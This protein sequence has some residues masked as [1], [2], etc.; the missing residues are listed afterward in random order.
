MPNGVSALATIAINEGRASRISD[1]SNYT[2]HKKSEGESGYRAPTPRGPQHWE[3]SQAAA[4]A[5]V[6]LR[7]R[8]AAQGR[9]SHGGGGGGVNWGNTGHKKGR[10]HAAPIYG[11][12]Y[13]K[14]RAKRKSYKPVASG[15]ATK[16]WKNFKGA[17]KTSLG[18]RHAR[19]GE[20]LKRARKKKGA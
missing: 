6:A 14:I 2:S 15:Q 8:M 20:A 5:G 18:K 9:M 17:S 16:D 7:K 19:T 13:S 4:L 1:W 3:A 10:F 12:A 11:K